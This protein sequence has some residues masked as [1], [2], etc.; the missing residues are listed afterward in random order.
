MKIAVGGFQHETNTFAPMKADWAAFQQADSWPA[1]QIG[2]SLLSACAGMN[3]PVAGFVEKAQSLGHSFCAL[4]WCSATPSGYVT[5]DAYDRFTQMLLSQLRDVANEVD[6]VYLDLHGAMVAE[7]LEDGEGHLL[8]KVRELVG[9]DVWLVAS[10]DLHA[11]ITR[12][13]VEAADYLDVFRT[14]PH[15]D[16]AATGARVAETLDQLKVTGV[17]PGKAF[18]KLD[19]LIPLTGSC[20][21]EEPGKSIY[22]TVSALAEEA[23]I[24]G[25][26]FATGFSPADIKECGPSVLIYG[27]ELDLIASYADRLVQA[28]L[29]QEADFAANLWTAS[30][31]IDLAKGKKQTGRPA[32]LADTQDNPGAGGNG[33]TVGLLKALVADQDVKAALGVLYDPAAAAAARA[34]GVGARVK[35]DLG[36]HTGGAPDETPLTAAFDVVAL[37]DGEFI[38]KGPYYD[39]AHISVGPAA[40]LQL[41]SVQIVV[42]SKK[43][44]C[45]D[46]AMFTHIGCDLTRMDI[47]AVKSS[48]HFRAD[49]NAIASQVL[50]VASP[51]P[52]PADHCEL[53]YRRLRSGVRLMP[54]THV[55]QR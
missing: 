46:R 9:P 51:G 49:F 32:I 31:A 15:V 55:R 3:I 53:T 54:G 1:M 5:A 2:P 52:N 17:R 45:A 50:V 40:L 44:Q 28:V 22:A 8:Q 43:V 24:V 6:A 39:G 19:F 34:A 48:V 23:G 20:T 36:A 13:M 29:A 27:E 37:S 38:A 11:N 41:D 16:M 14:Y 4:S 18:R 7:H 42:A 33:D 26:S 47:V 21:L 35:L 30:E 10:L 25:A 12:A